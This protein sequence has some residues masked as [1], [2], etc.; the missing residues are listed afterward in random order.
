MET[1]SLIIEI[2]KE[3]NHFKERSLPFYYPVI[4]Q[5]IEFVNEVLIRGENYS[6]GSAEFCEVCGN[7]LEE[8]NHEIHHIA[9]SKHSPIC[10]DICSSCHSTITKRQELWDDRWRQKDQPENIRTSF[11]IQGLR[12]IILLRG[13][14]LH[15][16]TIIEMSD[17]LNYLASSW[18]QS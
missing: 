9:G 18:R 3:L 1:D 4:K 8:H 16:K 11:L 14:L 13:E 2:N 10:I 7:K 6:Y 15:S 12:E 5:T 17:T